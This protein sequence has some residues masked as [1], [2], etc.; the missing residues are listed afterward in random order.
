MTNQFDLNNETVK[1]FW[2]HRKK[3]DKKFGVYLFG[4]IA[5][6]IILFILYFINELT[7]GLLLLGTSISFL[8]VI[9]LINSEIKDLNNR[10]AMEKE[11]IGSET[12]DLQTKIYKIEEKVKIS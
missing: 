1:K 3:N 9:W 2:D 7:I 4:I 11:I 5:L 8:F 10:I 6:Y 12:D